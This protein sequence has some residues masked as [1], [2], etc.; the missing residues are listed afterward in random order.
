MWKIEKQVSS[1]QTEYSK[2][3][4]MKISEKQNTWECNTTVMDLLS[5]DTERCWYIETEEQ[6]LLREFSI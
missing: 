2:Q 3:D 1:W 6:S 5:G 4:L